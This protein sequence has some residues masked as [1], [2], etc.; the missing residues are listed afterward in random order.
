MKLM[1]NKFI[2]KVTLFVCLALVCASGNS[3]SKG[4]DVKAHYLD[5][6]FGAGYEYGGVGFQASVAPIPY[7]SLFAGF[8]FNGGAGW[9][10]G[11]AWHI[12]PKTTRYMFRPFI[13]G[14]Y[15]YNL[16]FI[17]IGDTYYVKQYYGPSV[18]AGCEMRFGKKK[19]HGVDVSLRYAFWSSEAWDAYNNAD[20]DSRP[21]TGAFG[22]SIGYHIEF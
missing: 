19:R 22:L 6:G 17:T 3:Q 8:G 2:Q 4:G 14:M 16:V 1:K 15:G 18:G 5:F 21:A 13:E 20:S 11:A 12:L 9:N 10:I 7:A